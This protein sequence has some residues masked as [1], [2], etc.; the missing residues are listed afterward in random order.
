MNVLFPTVELI[1]RYTIAMVK[2][3]KTNG[4]NQ[5][6]LNYYKVQVDQLPLDQINDDI[7]R[8]QEIHEHIWSLESE[9][10]SG[11]ENE[12]SLDEIGRRA[13]VIRNWNNKRITIKNRIADVLGL[14]PV[15]EIKRQHLSE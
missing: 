4:Q 2:F 1:D 6:E 9:L 15:R 14:D 7:K 13:I 8:L 5:E 3:C 11:R 12:L 10:K